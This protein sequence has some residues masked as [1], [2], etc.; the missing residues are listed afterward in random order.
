VP[1]E[2]SFNFFTSILN[3]DKFSHGKGEAMRR[4]PLIFLAA[5]LLLGIVVAGVFFYL[6]RNSPRFALHQMV[7]T[8]MQR[9]YN[10]FYS[11]LDM[12][13]ILG[14]LMQD[15]GKDLIPPELIPKGNFL[16][17]L[18]L[19][20]G[21]KVAQ[22]LVP[23]IYGT[24]EKEAQ[25]V[26]NQYLDT[27]TTQD[28]LALEGAV[29]LAQINQNGDEAQ[30]TLRFPKDEASLHLT[31]GRTPQDRTWRIISVSYED[32]KELVKKKIF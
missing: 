11:F 13:S 25:K 31:M 32:L 16:G 18:G 3:C 9:N 5:A 17:E 15:T 14:S 6:Y 26:I 22:Q 30:V 8:L 19:K 29:A 20:M 7:T 10:K 23:Q 2:N 28:L 4:S 24:F 27:L 12:K 21:S 1:S